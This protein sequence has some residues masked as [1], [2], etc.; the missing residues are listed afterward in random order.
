MS[1]NGLRSNMWLL[2]YEADLKGWL[3]GL[4]V[5]HVEGDPYFSELKGKQISFYDTTKN[6]ELIDHG[7]GPS[8]LG[9]TARSVDGV[10]AEGMALARSIA[11]G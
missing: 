4:A 1:S 2:A 5:G 9:G 3:H 11:G 10:G 8:T 7:D 6:V